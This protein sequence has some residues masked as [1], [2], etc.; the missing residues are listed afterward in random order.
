[1]CGQ[2]LTLLPGEAYIPVVT[3]FLGKGE[4]TGAICTLGRG[5]SDLSATV[6]GAALDLEEA[7]ACALCVLPVRV[8][9]L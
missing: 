8:C 5:G 3:G 2:A 6:I 4:N 7:R 1:M 9:S